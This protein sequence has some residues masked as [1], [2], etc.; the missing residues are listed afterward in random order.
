M[1]IDINHMLQAYGDIIQERVSSGWSPYLLT[2]MFNQLGG[3][4][5]TQK[6]TMKKEVTA[7]YF[8]LL[9]RMHRHPKNMPFDLKSLWIATPDLPVAKHYKISISDASLNDGLHYHAMALIAPENRLGEPLDDYLANNQQLFCGQDRMLRRLH[10]QYIV[11]DADYVTGYAM[12]AIK[13]RTMSIEDIMILPFSN[14]ERPSTTKWERLQ[15]KEEGL[16][17]RIERKSK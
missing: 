1:K 8:K 17:R 4:S 9:T 12:K 16:L 14:S 15:I 10:A 6:E 5:K 7:T 13:R 2:F 3:S 11:N